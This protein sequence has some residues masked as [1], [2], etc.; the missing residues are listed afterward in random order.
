ML[1]VAVPCR[2][3]C[4]HLF[5]HVDQ[6]LWSQFQTS[7]GEGIVPNRI[8]FLSC[9]ILQCWSRPDVSWF[10]RPYE[11]MYSCVKKCRNYFISW[12]SPK[13]THNSIRFDYFNWFLILRPLLLKKREMSLHV[14]GMMRLWVVRVMN[15]WE[16]RWMNWRSQFTS[17]HALY[18]ESMKIVKSYWI[19]GQFSGKSG[20]KKKATFF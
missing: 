1:V 10:Y 20:K 2:F 14:D 19:M 17:L 4:G 8:F 5:R 9:V 7:E 6:W 18:E 11:I 3:R 13:L 15:G 16:R 12:F